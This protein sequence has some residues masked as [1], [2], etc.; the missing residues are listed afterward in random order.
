MIPFGQIKH[1]EFGISV[2]TDTQVPIFGHLKGTT[3][4]S[5]RHRRGKCIQVWHVDQDK[6][7]LKQEW[8]EHHFALHVYRKFFGCITCYWGRIDTLVYLPNIYRIKIK[9][10]WIGKYTRQAWILWVITAWHANSPICPMENNSE[11]SVSGRVYWC[12]V[13][14]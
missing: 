10:S 5:G 6:S 4:S 12:V 3:A 2:D 1:G 7:Q 13:I 11:L 9:H 14:K 8:K